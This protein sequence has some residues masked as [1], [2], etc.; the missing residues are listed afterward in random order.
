LSRAVARR[1]D[2][3]WLRDVRDQCAAADVPFHIKQWAGPPGD[4]IT[5]T[6]D[7]SGKIHLPM[8]DGQ[9]FGNSP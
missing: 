4:G 3:A 8:L 2:P 5:G 9:T 1:T 7:R 6:P